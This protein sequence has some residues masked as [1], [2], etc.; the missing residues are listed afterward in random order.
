M[1]SYKM[2]VS[3]TINLHWEIIP[4]ISRLVAKPCTPVFLGPQVGYI[5]IYDA[6]E[7]DIWQGAKVHGKLRM[8][9]WKTSF[10]PGGQ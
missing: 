3:D 10:Q 6:S 7:C 4:L 9:W 8:R 1:K 5:G 2:F